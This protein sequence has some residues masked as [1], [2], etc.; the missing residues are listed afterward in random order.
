MNKQIL[1]FSLCVIIIY[2]TGGVL[3]PAV[4]ATQPSGGNGTHFCGV[5]DS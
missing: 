1:R 3:N 4:A 5:I 2:L